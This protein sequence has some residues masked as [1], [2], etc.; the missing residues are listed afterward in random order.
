MKYC[1]FL[2][3]GCFF[4][5]CSKKTRPI[6]PADSKIISKINFD[7]SLF[8]ENGLY[9]QSNAKR[10][11]DYEFCV[12]NKDILIQKVQAID[13][14]LKVNK[15]AKG[16]I[17]CSAKEVLCLGNTH[18]KRYKTILLE[19]AALDFVKRIDPTYFE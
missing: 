3:L 8:D 12:T 6:R 13:P 9:G 14:S 15:V 19:L 7:L 10:A 18:Q 17:G 4:M 2:L 1:L 16:R 5:A 11:M